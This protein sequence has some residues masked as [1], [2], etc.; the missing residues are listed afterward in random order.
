MSLDKTWR[1]TS[2]RVSR[3]Q[4]VPTAYSSMCTIR[5]EVLLVTPRMTLNR[6]LSQRAVPEIPGHFSTLESC[7]FFLFVV[8][9]KHIKFTN[10]TMFKFIIQ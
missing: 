6:R 2:P 1:Q 4:G 7:F 3:I 8:V 10:L 9:I 5:K